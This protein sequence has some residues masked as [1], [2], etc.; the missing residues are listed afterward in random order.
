MKKL[1][2]GEREGYTSGKQKMSP[3]VCN[4]QC[5][6][7]CGT[8]DETTRANNFDQSWASDSSTTKPTE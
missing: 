5:G 2:E 7:A 8:G 3:K 1:F 6:C 4:C